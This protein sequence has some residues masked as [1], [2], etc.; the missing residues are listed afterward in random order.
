VLLRPAGAAR[1][2]VGGTLGRL[3][4]EVAHVARLLHGGEHVVDR[5]ER[6]YELL[7]A[8][9]HGDD[10]ELGGDELAEG[11][12]PVDHEQGA[13]H[14]EAAGDR[15]L[16]EDDGE[17][18]PHE[19]AEVRLARG[20]VAAHL[21]VHPLEREA[22]PGREPEELGGA[23]E[24]LQPV[25]DPVLVLGLGEARGQPAAPGD[26][27]DRAE[28]A[29]EENAEER[30]VRVVEREQDEPEDDREERRRRLREQ[31]GEAL[32]D[33]HDLEE[34]VH[35]LG[36]VLAERGLELQARDAEGVLEGHAREHA[37]LQP[38]HDAELHDLQHPG[39][40]RPR[41]DE[42]DE[43][44]HRL[45]D[46]PARDEPHDRL[47]AERQRQAEEPDQPRVQVDEP[48]LAP[49]AH[50]EPHEPPHRRRM[51]CESARMVGRGGRVGVR[52]GMDGR[53]RDRWPPRGADGACPPAAGR[54]AR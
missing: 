17:R 32:L 14:E 7:D 8:G 27:E 38:L 36:E 34:A 9:E 28:D 35:R 5:A 26:P 31:L 40:E 43:E 42:A 46:E 1:G 51:A 20:H 11:D 25:G 24:L 47:H 29:E 2:E 23:G 19:H 48:D 44:H 18:L 54:A 15:G 45:Q 37:L 21:G 6:E 30:E 10:H 3:E 53:D 4:R 49:L 50:E 33:D 13:E 52:H 12:L 22:R 41:D 16:E 39:G